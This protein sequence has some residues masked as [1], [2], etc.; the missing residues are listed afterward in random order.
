MRSA[1][2]QTIN[3]CEK[4]MITEL[5]SN[6]R[7]NYYGDCGN[8]RSQ[9]GVPWDLANYTRVVNGA[10][11]L[12]LNHLIEESDSCQMSA[13]HYGINIGFRGTCVSLQIGRNVKS[14]QN[15][16]RAPAQKPS[17]HQPP[18]SKELPLDVT[19]AKLGWVQITAFCYATALCFA[20]EIG[21]LVSA[22]EQRGIR[23]A[24]SIRWI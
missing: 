4:K 8:R 16:C 6:R 1:V 23:T 3:Q 12:T 22:H 9:G 20:S 10:K 5:R 18:K 13:R 21:S 2:S 19:L 15:R 17:P 7:A 14:Q 11:E 24:D